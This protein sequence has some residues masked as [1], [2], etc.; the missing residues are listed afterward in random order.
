M[1]RS[2]D[3]E[4]KMKLYIYY[5]LKVF[6]KKNSNSLTADRRIENKRSRF[7]F[8]LENNEKEKKVFYVNNGLCGSSSSGGIP[9]L[10]QFVSIMKLFTF[11]VRWWNEKCARSTRRHL[12][13]WR[14]FDARTKQRNTEWT[15]WNSIVKSI[16]AE[17][18]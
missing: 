11:S 9:S 2:S 10:F 6:N 1:Q 16:N 15:G 14:P 4:R 17:H 5:L 13:A 12:I 3:E 7:Y 18:P 8:G